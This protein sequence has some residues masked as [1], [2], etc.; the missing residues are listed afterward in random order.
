MQTA[1][2]RSDRRPCLSDGGNSTGTEACGYKRHG[3]I[4]TLQ[5][6]L[7]HSKAR[8]GF[9]LVELLISV[10]LAAML[11]LAALSAFVFTL[12]GE[13]SLANYSEMNTRARMVLEQM[14]RDFRSAGDVP[15]GSFSSTSVL[16]K[17]PTD[18]TATAWQ[19]VTWTYNASAGSV[20]RS[21]GGVD[22]VYATHVTSFV[23]TYYNTA[24]VAPGNDVELKQI[25]LSMRLLRQVQSA[26]T[27]E[28]IMSAQYTLRAKSTTS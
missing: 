15:A 23:F 11:T 2:T 9:T 14:G 19:N 21:V 4:S 20:T 17:L 10:S 3:N 6:R 18:S 12:R 27:S 1:F 26:A 8:T 7:K 16:L 28:L 25:Q 5:T 13:R 22:T 24:G